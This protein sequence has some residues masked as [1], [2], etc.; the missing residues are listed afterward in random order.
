MSG[1]YKR[2]TAW[3]NT[4]LKLYNEIIYY[5]ASVDK[6][7][8]RTTSNNL[9]VYAMVTVQIDRPRKNWGVGKRL[10]YIFFYTS[11]IIK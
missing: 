8:M 7:E 9:R 2:K 1:T 5:L 11:G 6:T 4:R 10:I 3:C